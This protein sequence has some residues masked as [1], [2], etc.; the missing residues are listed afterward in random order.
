M[1][2]GSWLDVGGC[3][4]GFW[5]CLEGVVGCFICS[6]CIG[7]FCSWGAFNAFGSDSF[8]NF[9]RNKAILDASITDM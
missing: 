3:T 8:S 5:A 6:F 2:D 7:S 4:K 1:V 9:L